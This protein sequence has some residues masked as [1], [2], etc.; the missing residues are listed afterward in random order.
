MI[1]IVLVDDHKIFRQ[2]L[3]VLLNSNKYFEIVAQVGDG[4]EAWQ[5]I[6][7]NIPDV[8]ILDI[9]M[10]GLNGIEVVQKVK[11]WGLNT[12]S[13]LLTCHDDPTLAIQGQEAGAVGFVLKENSF[14]ELQQAVKIVQSG[15]TF[16]SEKMEF[17][18]KDFN[19]SGHRKTLSMREQEVLK[20]I[21]LGHTNKEIARLLNISP[22]TVDS[23]KTR[24]KEKLEMRTISELSC[25]AL[26]VGLIT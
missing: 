11:K 6:K 4:N 22:R 25:Y 18:I 23:H 20:H 7:H 9:T 5:F 10:P 19:L 12:K 24:I 8:A 15:G 1:K 3:A 16:L 13:I 2:G 17:K 26:R 21:S 14:D